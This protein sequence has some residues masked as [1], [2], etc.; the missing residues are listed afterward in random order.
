MITP[1]DDAIFWNEKPENEIEVLQLVKKDIIARRSLNEEFVTG[2]CN[3]IYELKA[4]KN[5]DRQLVWS[6]LNLIR[7]KKP[8][9]VG[10]IELF[11]PL[12]KAGNDQ[13]IKIIDSII[14]ELKTKNIYENGKI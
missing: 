4:M 3:A 14:E 5:I 2:I 8:E 9:N 12:N 6:C 11:W 7:K 13:R 10:M 1:I